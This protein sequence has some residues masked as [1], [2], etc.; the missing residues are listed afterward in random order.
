MTKT[1]IYNVPDRENQ[2][3]QL[4]TSLEKEKKLVERIHEEN[5][6]KYDQSEANHNT[7]NYENRLKEVTKLQDD[8]KRINKE[9]EGEQKRLSVEIDNNKKKKIKSIEKDKAELEKQYSN[10]KSINLK[11]ETKIGHQ[12][13]QRTSETYSRHEKTQTSKCYE[14]GS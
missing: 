10:L 13:K 12:D 3:K 8:V 4:Q 14:C 7:K 6:N 9:K 1:K 11:L 2:T 5:R